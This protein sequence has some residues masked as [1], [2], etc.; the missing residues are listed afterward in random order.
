[1]STMTNVHTYNI[2]LSYPYL[3]IAGPYMIKLQFHGE[4]EQSLK[5]YRQVEQG[6]SV[7][8]AQKCLL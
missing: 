2:T 1:M 7:P 3:I 8:Q 5:L 6:M 4:R